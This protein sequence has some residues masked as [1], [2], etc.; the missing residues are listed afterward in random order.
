M[1]NEQSS[2]A[3]K[4]GM[5][6]DDR[7]LVWVMGLPV[8]LFALLLLLVAFGPDTDPEVYSHCDGPDKVFITDGVKSKAMDVIHNHPD[9][10][11]K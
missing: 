4:K 2:A 5:Q 3:P 7:M 6:S 11:E 10:K 1:E 9:C 8:G